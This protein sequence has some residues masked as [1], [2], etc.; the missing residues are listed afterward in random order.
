MDLSWAGLPPASDPTLAEHPDASAL[1]EEAE[2]CMRGAGLW[3]YS[4]LLPQVAAGMIT[5]QAT[6]VSL[7]RALRRTLR[8]PCWITGIDLARIRTAADWLMHAA[9][10]DDFTRL[11]LPDPMSGSLAGQEA[12]GQ[13]LSAADTRQTAAAILAHDQEGWPE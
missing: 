4:P 9:L 5:P 8:A 11:V 6:A 7:R 10:G 12:T 2:E 13:Y 1:V 3:P